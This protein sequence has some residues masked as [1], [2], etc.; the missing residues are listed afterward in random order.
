VIRRKKR[1]GGRSRFCWKGKGRPFTG[2]RPGGGEGDRGNIP[3]HKAWKKETSGSGR[4]KGSRRGGKI[5]W[6]NEKRG[7]ANLRG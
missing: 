5:R 6:T 1:K 7:D 2:R 3:N 4:V